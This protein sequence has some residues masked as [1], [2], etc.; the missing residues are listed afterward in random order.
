MTA[1]HFHSANPKP[2]LQA[3]VAITVPRDSTEGLSLS[4]ICVH[5]CSRLESPSEQ[6]LGTVPRVLPAPQFAPLYTRLLPVEQQA[7]RFCGAG[8]LQCYFI[9]II[10]PS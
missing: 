1:H 5:N 9:S 10:F 4:L 3:G 8:T 2:E 6:I 7:E